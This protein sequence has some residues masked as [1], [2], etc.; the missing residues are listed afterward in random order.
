MTGKRPPSAR[1]GEAAGGGAA[2]TLQADLRALRSTRAHDLP[3]LDQTAR[4]LRK[5]GAENNPGG[6][7]MTMFRKTRTR[8]GLLTAAAT[9]VVA[10]ALLFIPV[11]YQKTVGRDVALTLSGPA[12]D[13]SQLQKIAREFKASLGAESVA[14]RM[15]DGASSVLTAKVSGPSGARADRVARAFARNLVERGFAADVRTTRRVERVLGSL[16]ALA[17]NNIIEIR[18]SSDGKSEAQVADEIRG[19]LEAAGIEHPVVDYK[20][21]GDRTTLL[22]EAQKTAGA[23]EDTTLCNTDIRVS[24]DG[25]EPSPGQIERSTVKV[26]RTPDM[27]DEQVIEEVQRQLREQ[28]READVSIEN[29]RIVIR[30]RTP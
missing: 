26:R 7:L 14:L 5:L 2:E 3:T 13:A 28:G 4:S 1:P 16:Y 30:P 11:S 24:V 10:V 21:E 27:T 6:S 22:I 17:M 15:E 12:L 25:R 19:Q 23:G 20:R 8:R 29:G 18:V 9:A